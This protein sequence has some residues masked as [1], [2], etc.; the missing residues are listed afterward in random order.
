[1]KSHPFRIF[2]SYSH[3]DIDKAERVHQIL[4]EM[5]LE[6]LWDDHIR[7][8]S[9][10]VELVKRGWLGTRGSVSDAVTLPVRQ[11]RD[12][13]DVMLAVSD[14]GEPRSTVSA[15]DGLDYDDRMAEIDLDD[16]DDIDLFSF[17]FPEEDDLW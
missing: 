13:R 3:E 5:G 4:E 14:T 12:D 15:T 1:M 6:P 9:M 2:I 7:P 17:D 10:F 11:A 8:G 16:T